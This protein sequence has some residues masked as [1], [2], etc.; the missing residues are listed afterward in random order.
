MKSGPNVLL[1]TADQWR[2]DCLSGLDHPTVK[3]PHLDSL[4]ADGVLFRNHFAQC[5]PCGP[6]RASLY[7]GQ[8]MMNHR[9]VRNGV[10]LDAR[11]T[12]VA[13]EARKGGYD[14]CLLGYTDTSVDPREY[15]PDDPILSTYAGVLPGFR[16]MAPGTENDRNTAWRDY[17]AA[18]GYKIPSGRGEIRRPVPD[19]PGAEERGPTFAPSFYSA[20]DS[21][22][23]F[24][25]NHA[26]SFVESTDKQPWFL[27]LSVERPH[28]PFIAPEPYNAM[29]HPDDVPDFRRA[30]SPE[31]ESLQHPFV[32][33][34]VR[35]HLGRDG[36]NP[37]DQPATEQ[38]MR[39]L[40]ATYFGL[41]AEVDHHMGRLFARL[42][43]LGQYDDCLIVFTSDHG[44]QLWDHWLLG[45]EHYFDQSFHVPLIVRAPGDNMDKARGRIVE[46]F[47]ESVD[48]MP[49]ILD[50]LGLTIPLQC[51]GAPLSKF[52]TGGTP[53][54]WRQEAHWELDFRD[55][56]EGMPE[57]ELGIRLDE[58]SLSVVRDFDFKYVHF[59]AL[60]PMLYDLKNDPNELHNVAEDSAYRDTALT[61]A[62]KVLSWRMANAER[63][64]TGIRLIEGGPF[65]CPPDRRFAQL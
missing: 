27:H 21:D 2:G 40:R 13:L 48:V 3:T 36:H 37:V 58:C 51:D 7:S 42:K 17:L 39:Q 11:F 49:T 63:T 35:N 28:P 18:K 41:M 22:T 16:L 61:F 47:T 57:K 14:P 10:P 52:L 33:Y 24:M 43:E 4:A 19:Y 64:L 45:K 65:E 15:H 34:M 31:D 62:R 32:A 46:A 5:A 59:T 44:E 8:Y 6:S 30:P 55:I 9:S 54:D 38:A 29:F 20:E 12:N 25:V 1:I 50:R 56:L 60:P 26:I 53:G 23:A